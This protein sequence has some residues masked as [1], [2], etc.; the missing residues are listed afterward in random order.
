MAIQFHGLTKDKC[1]SLAYEYAVRN[2]LEVPKSWR[3]NEKAGQ[4][5]WLSFKERHHLAIRTPEA[6]SLARATSFNRYTVGTF[7]DNLARV[8]DKHKFLS[9]DIYNVDETGCTTV[10]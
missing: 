4:D 2:G 10:Q 5:F 6:T 3:D 8:M 7:F 9:H 1:R